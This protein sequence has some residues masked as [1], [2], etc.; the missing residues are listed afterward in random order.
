[1]A[2]THDKE[3]GKGL[4]VVGGV[5]S[6]KRDHV[7]LGGLTESLQ[8]RLQT[9]R[10]SPREALGWVLMVLVLWQVLSGVQGASELPR[11]QGQVREGG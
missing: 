6:A 4:R 10:A 7:C 1:M 9:K 2:M 3:R 5:M 8:R 11:H